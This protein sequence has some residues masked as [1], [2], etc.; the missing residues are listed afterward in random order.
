MAVLAFGGNEMGPRTDFEILFITL[1]L[2]VFLL[3]NASLFGTMTMLVAL[4]S[5]KESEFQGQVDVANTAMKNMELPKEAQN[6][7]RFYLITTQGTQYEQ[8]Q[9]LKFLQM[10]S[11]SLKEQVSIEIF[12]GTVKKNVQLRTAIAEITR[13][14][15]LKQSEKEKKMEELIRM[16]V[17]R[18]E[19]ELVEPDK[20]IISKY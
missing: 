17:M 1:V 15:H 9:L 19:T 20:V 12:T 5:K 14:F 18:M 10:I 13:N 7:V 16:I 2:I 4:V 8:D 6:E 3:V 11:P